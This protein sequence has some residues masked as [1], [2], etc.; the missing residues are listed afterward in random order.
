MTTMWIKKPVKSLEGWTYVQ[1][2]SYG[3]AA[4]GYCAASPFHTHATETEARLCYT[5]WRIEN[6]NLEMTFS[7]FVPCVY[8]ECENLTKAGVEVR[9]ELGCRPL[10]SEHLNHAAACAVLNLLGPSPDFW[11]M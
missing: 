3:D 10:C 2:W 1:R 11:G 9:G 4:I 7:Q 8:P 6:L 5:A